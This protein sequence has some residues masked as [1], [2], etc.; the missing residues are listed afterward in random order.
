MPT[1]DTPSRA[2]TLKAEHDAE[3]KAARDVA[4]KAEAEDRDFTDAERVV[5]RDHVEKAR[6]LKARIATV[7]EDAELLGAVKAFEAGLATKTAG[8]TAN[9]GGTLGERFTRDAGIADYLKRLT[10]T[11]GYIGEKTRVQSD[12]VHFAGLK[13]LLGHHGTK[14]ILSGG[15]DAGAGAFLSPEF[16]GVIDPFGVG[17]RPLTLRQ[18]VTNGTTG[19]DEVTYA[20]IIDFTSAAAPVAEASGS[21][22]GGG[23]GDVT[24]TKPESSLE[25]E[26]IHETV[27]TVAHWLPV[28]KRALSDAAQVRT[29]IDSFLRYG[30]EEELEDQIISGDGTGENFDGILHVSG[31]QTQAWSTDLFET[32][33]K[34]K[35]KAIVNGRA[36]N[37]TVVHSPAV[38]ERLDLAKDLNGQYFGGGPFNAGS[39]GTVWGMRRVETEAI[40]DN[41]AIVGDF[42]WSIL[43]DREQAAV[44]MSDSHAD[45]FVRN[46]VALLAELRAAFGVIRPAAFV[47]TDVTA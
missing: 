7:T 46:L 42:G 11:T 29:L 10:G 13:D 18:V 12:A 17:Q 38:S 45:F 25:Y 4:T 1:T 30:L 44:M 34:A 5:V 27:K 21:S 43:W 16:L 14:D 31:T 24:G 22:E 36:R 40:D 2:D 3:L 33:R 15:S 47:I 35:T 23:S 28:T 20:R 32:L 39:P 41:N 8:P 26:Q 6:A 9:A 19:T 37:L